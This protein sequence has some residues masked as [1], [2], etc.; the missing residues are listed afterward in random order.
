MSRFIY[1]LPGLALLVAS[2]ATSTAFA[3][4]MPVADQWYGQEHAVPPV[5]LAVD[6]TPG[7]S[8]VR[9]QWYLDTAPATPPAAA[10]DQIRLDPAA[11]H[12]RYLDAAN[13]GDIAGA[14]VVFAE[15]ATY[16]GGSCQP[17]PCVGRVAIQQDL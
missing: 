14:V 3:R 13:R 11:V 9:D 1:V 7:A 8:P 2:V 16:R 12:Q 15:D 4:S 5:G 17:D 10:L 6:T